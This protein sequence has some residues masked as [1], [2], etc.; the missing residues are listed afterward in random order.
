MTQSLL[1]SRSGD[2]QYELTECDTNTNGMCSPWI[3]RKLRNRSTVEIEEACGFER[4]HVDYAFATRLNMWDDVLIALK[5]IDQRIEFSGT[6]DWWQRDIWVELPT[7]SQ[8]YEGMISRI[9]VQL[10]EEAWRKWLR[11][12]VPCLFHLTQDHLQNVDARVEAMIEYQ[13]KHGYQKAREMSYLL[14]EWLLDSFSYTSTFPKDCLGGS[15]R[16]I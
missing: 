7:E 14:S 1:R 2:M 6:V 3:V 12:G 5:D 4:M 10:N 11:P 8:L 13:N 16:S 15:Q 9:T